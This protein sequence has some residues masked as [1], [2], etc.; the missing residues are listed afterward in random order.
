MGKRDVG[1]LFRSEGEEN[2]RIICLKSLFGGFPFLYVLYTG[3]L[4]QKVFFFLRGHIIPFYK[5]ILFG[6]STR[7]GFRAWIF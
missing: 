4:F 6:G 3:F 1:L 2:C 7:I 5:S